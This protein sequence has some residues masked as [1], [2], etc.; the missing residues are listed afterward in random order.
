MKLVRLATNMSPYN[1]FMSQRL[2]NTL[3][4]VNSKQITKEYVFK[5]LSHSKH[6]KNMLRH[7]LAIIL[8]LF[9]HKPHFKYMQNLPAKFH[10]NI[11][12]HFLAIACQNYDGML[13]NMKT[14]TLFKGLTL[15]RK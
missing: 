13:S 9:K 2:C 6:E 14:H 7:E 12:N 1:S 5:K 10:P 15:A 3:E 8:S 11:S 4:H